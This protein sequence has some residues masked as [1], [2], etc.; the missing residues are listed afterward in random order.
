MDPLLV[1]RSE[2]SRNWMSCDFPIKLVAQKNHFLELIRQGVLIWLTAVPDLR[3]A[4]EA[5]AGALHY[6]NSPGEAHPFRRRSSPRR[7]AQSGNQPAILFAPFTHAEG[8]TVARAEG[9]IETS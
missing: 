4:K 2:I 8:T 1:H 6:F 9:S 7:C 5:E 3:L